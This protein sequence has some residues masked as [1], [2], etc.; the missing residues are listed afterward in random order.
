MIE[1]V[2]EFNDALLEKFVE[3]E[4]GTVEEIKAAIRRGTIDLNITPVLAGAAFKDKGIQNVLDAVVDYLPAPSE[5]PPIEGINPETGDSVV[6]PLQ[7]DQPMSALAFK[8]ISDP[9]GDLTFVRIYT[10]V[11]RQGKR[12]INGRNSRVVV[13]M[14]GRVIIGEPTIKGATP[15]DQRLRAY[16][17]DDGHVLWSARLPAQPHATPMSY[18]LDGKQYVVIAAGGNRGDSKVR[19]DYLVAFS[20]P[21]V[22]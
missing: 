18:E 3:G 7:P 4:E 17:M 2:A 20:L 15:F 21:K 5:V 9:N 11:M 10:G 8:T 12:Y 14:L 16:D 1:S 22:K 19:G 13:Q 6:R